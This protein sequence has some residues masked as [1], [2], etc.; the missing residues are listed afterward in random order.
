M[1]LSVRLEQTSP[2][3]YTRYWSHEVSMSKIHDATDFA[4]GEAN[5]VK[6]AVEQPKVKSE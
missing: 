2:T 6:K 4:S 5:D 1:A 3:R